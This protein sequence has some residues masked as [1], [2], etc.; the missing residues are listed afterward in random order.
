MKKR[1]FV[2]HELKVL[3][4]LIKR[5]MYNDS[6]RECCSK[7]SEIQGLLIGY[8][9]ENI[10]KDIFQKDI[11]EEFTIRRSTATG[12]LQS[13]E[14]NGYITRENVSYD[15]R[16][17]KIVLTENGQSIYKHIV[18]KINEFESKITKDVSEEELEMFV[19]ILNKF[20]KNLE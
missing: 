5:H 2:G 6:G 19:E 7:F 9:N 14:K 10:N 3:S 18:S 4:N 1:I 15:A 16:L 8:L 17:K 12:I 13:M 20:K 11:E